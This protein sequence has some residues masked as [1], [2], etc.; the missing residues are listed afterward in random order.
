MRVT[1]GSPIPI[2]LHF[3]PTAEPPESASPAPSAGNRATM[4][5]S[6][7]KKSAVSRV[8][9]TLKAAFDAWKLRSLEDLDVAYMYL[10]AIVLKVR[11][12]K[13]V[14]SMPVLVAIC[15]LASGEKQLVSLEAGSRLL[16]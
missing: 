11:S 8:I 1:N 6:P 7:A 15:A 16:S 2:L 9:V 5:Y 10:D 13:K 3:E 12:A 4:A 14:V